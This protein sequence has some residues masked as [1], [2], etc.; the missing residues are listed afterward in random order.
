MPCITKPTL[1]V[2][3]SPRFCD[4]TLLRVSQ[5]ARIVSVGG[6]SPAPRQALVQYPGRIDINIVPILMPI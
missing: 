4:S 6:F 5:P 2:P 1:E 3:V